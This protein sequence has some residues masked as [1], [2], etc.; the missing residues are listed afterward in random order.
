MHDDRL[1]PDGVVHV[2]GNRILAV[3]SRA[4]VPVPEDAN[5]LDVTGRTVMPG[6]VDVHSH[7]GA[8]DHRL[9]PQQSW[10]LLALL[11]FG[12]TTVHDPS[13]DTQMIYA[14]SELVRAGLRV[15]PRILSTGT[16]LY[17]A[18][19]D[20]KAAVNGYEDAYE[21]VKRT[22]AWGPRSVKSYQQPRRE[23]RQQVLRAAAEL[24][25]MVMPEGGSTLHYNVTHL[26]DG[27]TTLEHAIP[28]APLYE[29]ELKLLS[30]CGTCYTPTLVVGYGGFWGENYWY[31][32]TR[33]WEHERLLRFV[34]GS[35][36]MPNARR[37]TLLTDE[38]EYNHVRL[39]RTC[40]EVVRRG[41]TVEIGAHGQLQGL[42]SHWE[43]WMLV[44]GGLTPHEAL[45][46][47]TYGGARALCLDGC[48]G[49]L[50]PGHLADL[51]VVD[52]R[53]LEDVRDSERVRY[54][55]VNGRL[56]DA[57]TLEQILPE[58]LPL[59]AGPPLDTIRDTPGHV[60]CA[61]GR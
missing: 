56:Y 5:V 47:A 51:V 9:Y 60:H 7:T 28:V 37:R 43:T 49:S 24:G 18:E 48:L 59:P 8:S 29:P 57:A 50:Q 45:R 53:P 14:E 58:R 1:I 32:T 11:A 30:T 15:G 3:G 2:R 20:F 12:V 21:A 61:C 4:D 23:Q 41:G 31:A 10:A 44:Q 27:H 22:I 34:P 13:N 36:V 33:V 52:G 46:C 54:T 35:V 19:G 17:G 40:A 16:I 38:A 39:A 26:L 6:L 25:V 42:G 55:M